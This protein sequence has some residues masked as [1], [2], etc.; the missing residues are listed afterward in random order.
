MN[1]SNY[2]HRNNCG[3]G[4]NCD[5]DREPKVQK[6]TLDDGRN[7]ERRYYVD[8][9][10]NEVE[11]TFAEEARPKKLERRIVRERKNI[12]SREIHELVRNGEVLEREIRSLE[13]EVPLHVTER[14][15]LANRPKSNEVDYVSRDEIQKLVSEAVVSGVAALMENV[16][17]VI[18]NRK[19]AEPVFSAQSL[20]EQNVKEKKENNSASMFT[21]ITLG[22][23]F[24]AQIA[25]FAYMFLG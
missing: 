20:V 15:G 4:C 17:P 23:I 18:E 24:V 6:L 10:G 12:V 22:S 25:F 2:A 11:E 14:I 8:E 7:A 5:C 3:C 16:E 21:N 9:D 19:Q 1:N 13:P